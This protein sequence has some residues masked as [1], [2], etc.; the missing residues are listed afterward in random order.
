MLN[1]RNND[2]AAKVRKMCKRQ[3]AEKRK[4]A[5]D[6]IITNEFI[7]WILF[8]FLLIIPLCQLQRARAF[9]YSTNSS[10]AFYDYNGTA[11]HAFTMPYLGLNSPDNIDALSVGV[12]T[13]GTSTPVEYNAYT[14]DH[15]GGNRVAHDLYTF[16]LQPGDGITA[17]EHKV[18][19]TWA[20]AYGGTSKNYA[21]FIQQTNE[22][23]Y[24]VAGVMTQ[25][26]QQYPWI[27][28]LDYMGNIKWQKFYIQE[29]IV[30]SQAT[31]IRQTTDRGYIVV[32]IGMAIDPSVKSLDAWVMK[33]N[34]TGDVVWHK[35]YGG[36][37]GDGAYS[38]WQT[39]DGGYAVAGFTSS[40][41]VFG[42]GGPDVWV[43]KLDSDGN[44]QWQKVYG[45]VYSYEFHP[46]PCEDPNAKAC[47]KEYFGLS[48]DWA[49]SI[50]QTN[51]GGYIV[52]G[53]TQA[54][55]SATQD[56]WILRLDSTGNILWNR[57]FGRHT[58]PSLDNCDEAYTIR[59]TSDG[60]Y[61]VV[62]ATYSFG[63]RGSD[64]WVL[65][66][67]SMG[68]ILWQKA[69]GGPGYDG[70]SDN[71][72]Q[73][74]GFGSA[75]DFIEQTDDGGYIIVGDYDDGGGWLKLDQLGNIQWKK[76]YVSV[77][78]QSIQQTADKGYV[79]AGST[80]GDLL[81]LKMDQNGM[82]PGFGDLLYC[83]YVFIDANVT[84]IDTDASVGG[85]TSEFESVSGIT[86]PLVGD[87]SAVPRDVVAT[88]QNTSVSANSLC[89][90]SAIP[91]DANGDGTVSI[92]EVQKCINCFLGIEIEND[93][94]DKCDVNNDGQVTID[95][96]QKVINAFLG[97]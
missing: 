8:A 94:C 76:L 61:I 74:A 17:L 26:Y 63:A 53:S 89:P 11:L 2:I 65:K 52:A 82:V 41:T 66:L 51:D 90:A 81:V 87:S 62:G 37:W 4:I 92:D 58:D 72:G 1:R 16:G 54:W 20:K 96:V 56:F 24:V 44:I 86:N 84:V 39:R 9:V 73:F 78:P 18:C 25:N 3:T 85:I 12:N 7:L 77:Y 50:Q 79:V 30:G 29:N 57:L 64:F 71:N 35:V 40:F 68:N 36:H 43:F 91:G 93:C 59:Q 15:H 75:G 23:G 46:V 45:R 42:A 47:F 95:D 27:I 28:K 10:I 88:A 34:S 69:Y 6:S 13:T 67:D 49:N 19:S 60:G 22:G 31:C 14:G 80:P 32:G 21:N 70:P 83:P 55:G 48:S 97:K 5:C 38:V 33:L